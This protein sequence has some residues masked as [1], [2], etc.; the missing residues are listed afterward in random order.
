M[1]DEGHLGYSIPRDQVVTY[2]PEAMR[3]FQVYIYEWIDLLWF[4]RPPAE[5]LG[6]RSPEYVQV[7]HDRF[8]EAGWYGDGKIVLIWIPPFV[9]PHEPPVSPLG[10]VVWHVK[11]EEDGL[12]FLL[13]PSVLPFDE[14][15]G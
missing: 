14:F 6:D 11:Q 2:E 13:S 12:S 4:T 5:F 7:A 1:A 15:R 10:L 3:T 9:F 8:I